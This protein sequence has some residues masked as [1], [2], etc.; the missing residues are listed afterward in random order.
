MARRLANVQSPSGNGNP[1][2]AE[3]S[4]INLLWLYKMRWAALGGQLA[5]I[6][7]VHEWLEI[8][9]PLARLL[10]IVG[11]AAAT[12]VAL[13]MWLG[14]RAKAWPAW[15]G[16]GEWVSGS[17]MM[18]DN[19]FLTALLYYTG[20]PSNPFTVFY[21]VNI[22]LAAAVLPARWAWILDGAAF[23]CFALLFAMHVALEPLEHGHAHEHAMHHGT[24]LAPGPMSLHLQG[25]LIAFGGAATF[26]VYFI[27]RITNELARRE[28]ELDIARQRKAES[29]KLNALATLAA[30]AAHELASPL[31]TIAVLARDLELSMQAG[32]LSEDE[33]ADVKLIREEVDRCRRILDSMALG[34]GEC[35][36]EEW[37]PVSPQ[38]V[39]ASA[40]R[41]LSAAD[42]VEIATELPVADGAFK[43]PQ[44]AICQA[45]RA[46]IQNALDAS[47]P[48]GRVAVTGSGR[49][50][51]LAI[52]VADRG[53]GMPEDV[54]RRACEPFFTTKEPGSGMGL[55]LFFARRIIEQLGGSLT[56]E[57][58]LEQGTTVTVRLPLEGA[59]AG[60]G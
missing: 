50:G 25:S 21:L 6:V 9:V 22:A 58:T 18:L 15:A 40:I 53:S 33:T 14:R 23:L 5:T 32:N 51:L 13:G 27:T 1:W 45:L 7:L 3:R 42:R 17:L 38:E 46:I 8:E 12:N 36:G 19:L 60:V 43:L 28:A 16:R 55:G 26:I 56:L 49:D 44:A 52:V 11:L 48:A 37:V 34:A 39:L 35:I 29:D 20:G 31:S 30:G 24:R 4:R 2:I 59:A 54:L 41:E 10:A 57:S 47:G